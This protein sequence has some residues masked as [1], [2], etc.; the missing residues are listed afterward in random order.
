M[1]FFKDWKKKKDK[2]EYRR[3]YEHKRSENVF[4]KQYQP[5]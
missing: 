2:N 5:D 4:G 3:L 1:F